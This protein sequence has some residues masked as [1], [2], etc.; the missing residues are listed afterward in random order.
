MS[1]DEPGS[2]AAYIALGSNVGQRE[3]T[4]MSAVRKLDAL[5]GTKIVRLSNIYETEPVGYVEQ[6]AFLNM[7]AALET[8]LD[9]YALFAEMC[10]I[11]Q[12]AGR[13][14]VER[15]GPRTLDLDLLLYNELELNDPELMIPHPRM[16]ERQFVLVPL[17]DVWP[18]ANSRW[19][20]NLKSLQKVE[21]KDGIKLWKMIDWHS[22]SVHFVN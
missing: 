11:E 16:Q 5:A 6:P 10:R 9:P 17:L 8:A 21:G 14:R 15:W 2:N 3:Q 12:E 20:Q 1:K 18:E 13:V 19:H 22:E 7:V 4:L